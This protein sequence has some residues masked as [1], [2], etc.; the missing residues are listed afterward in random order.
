MSRFEKKLSL[1][2]QGS[3]YQVQ[4]HHPGFGK[5]IYSDKNSSRICSDKKRWP[6][7]KVVEGQE[8]LD[9]VSREVD[10]VAE[11]QVK[12][13]DMVHRPTTPEGATIPVIEITA[14]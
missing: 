8:D 10:Q 13:P 14:Q 5:D 11:D 2:P 6:L 7:T 9:V 4:E 1:E 12:D 3:T